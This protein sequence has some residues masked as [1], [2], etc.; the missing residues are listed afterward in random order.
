MTLKDILRLP[1]HPDELNPEFKQFH[2]TFNALHH[3]SLFWLTAGQNEARLCC[4]CKAEHLICREFVVN[5]YLCLSNR[6]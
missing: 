2:V 1:W 3:V 6:P 4:L 5:R